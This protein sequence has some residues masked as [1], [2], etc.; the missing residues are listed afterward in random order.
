MISSTSL[1]SELPKRVE[2][3][4]DRFD[5]ALSRSTISWFNELEANY[6][7]VRFSV[8]PTRSA[9]T[10]HGDAGREKRKREF[11][12][13]RRG[14][15]QLLLERGVHQPVGVNH[16][17]SPV[18]PEGFVGSISHSDQWTIATIG[19]S[20]TARSIGVDTEPIMLAE[21]AQLIA[22][23]IATEQEVLLVSEGGLEATTA[24]TLIFSAKESFYK[25]W[26]PITKRFL[27][28]KDVE[29]FDFSESSLR[30][31]TVEASVAEEAVLS[32]QYHVSDDNVFTF[33]ILE[34]LQ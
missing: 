4:V 29:V 8:R 6:Q 12:L 23:D 18:W 19:S 20:Q 1:R 11:L 27:E 28:F 3:R 13:G 26:H 21:T 2:S 17:R 31:R 30:L 5:A 10:L 22:G 24:L 25:C 16:D 14:T 7:G 15:A 33:A 32:V 9:G 34:D